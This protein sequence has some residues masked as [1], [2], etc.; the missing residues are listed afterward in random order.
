M[1]LFAG[2]DVGQD[3]TAIAVVDVSGEPLFSTTTLTSPNAIAVALKPYRRSLEK[4]GHETGMFTP[5]LHRELSRRRFP[6]ICLDARKTRAALAAQRNKTDQNDARDIAIALA[7]GFR[8][9]AYVKSEEAH[10]IRMLLTYRRALMRK[11]RDLE[12]TIRSSVKVFGITAKRKGRRSL[13]F[14]MPRRRSNSAVK[15][16]NA[17]MERAREALLAEATIL[18]REVQ[19]LAKADPVCARLMTAPGVGPITALTFKAAVDDPARF[20]QSRLVGAH[21]GLTPKRRQ[22]GQTDIGGRVSRLGDAWVRATLF[23]AA[24]SILT[25]T[26]KASVLRDWA[27][28]LKERKGHGKAVVACARKLAVVLHRMWVEEKNFDPRGGLK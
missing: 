6:M 17:I 13:I 26:N 4:V 5:Y 12:M 28:R 21:F 7:R 15:R 27:L 23:E 18:D 11:A 22:S 24:S 16:L 2:L 8:G 14:T 25:R 10:L 20:P 1:K 3:Q 19:A 9:V